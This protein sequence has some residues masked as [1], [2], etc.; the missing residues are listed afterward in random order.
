MIVGAMSPFQRRL[1]W[2]TTGLMLVWF[3]LLLV[4]LAGV[5]LQ[6]V[7]LERNAW[8]ILPCGLGAGIWLAGLV[9]QV[10][11]LR[12]TVLEFRY[13]DGV[14]RIHTFGSR[15]ERVYGLPDIAGV[16]F[17][18]GRGGHRVVLRDRG[19]LTLMPGLP[20]AVE[21]AE[22]LRYDLGYAPFVPVGRSWPPLFAIVMLGSGMLTLI[23]AGLD[24]FGAIRWEFVGREATGTVTAFHQP[25]AAA[26][27][28]IEVTYEVNGE[29]HVIRP[30]NW[31]AGHGKPAYIVGETVPVLFMPDQPEVGIVN[32]FR[33]RGEIT[34]FLSLFG[35]FA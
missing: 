35:L 18:R 2:M 27:S 12:A 5:V 22:Q 10:R 29:P 33:E 14:L 16:A 24:L 25:P 30:A 13:E 20:S 9:V 7:V 32:R 19:T 21:L 26:T 4:I 1:T 31:N 6:H 28:W 3:V 34:L 8:L 15:R 17:P 23:L 11:G